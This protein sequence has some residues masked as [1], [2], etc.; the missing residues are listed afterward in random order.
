MT[1]ARRE[2]LLAGLLLL[3]PLLVLLWA[4]VAGDGVPS[5]ADVLFATPFFAE[6][7]PPGFTRPANP[8]AFDVA[9]QFVPWRHFAWTSVRQG[10]LPLW[11]PYSLSGTPF[12]ASMQSAVFYPINLLLTPLPFA[13]TFAWSAL[14]RLWIAGFSA[15]LL[16]R[17][18]RVSPTGALVAGVSFMLCGYLIVWLGHPHTNVAVWL[19]ALVLAGE[20]LLAAPCATS[21]AL[22]A[23]LVGIQFTGGHVETSVD[24]LFCLGL[25]YVLRWWQVGGR[26]LGRLLP[27]ALAIALGTALAAAQLVPFLE[28]LPLSAEY[29]RR[30]PAAV[31]LFDPRCWRELLALPLVL[32]PNLYG[33]PTWPGPYHSYLP[34]GNYNENVLYVGTVPLLLALV[35]LRFRREPPV[36]ALAVLVLVAAGMAFHLPALDWPNALPGLARANPARLRLVTS[37]G[38][39]L[40][41]GFGADAV[42]DGGRPARRWFLGLAAAVVAA[43]V[44]VAAA[45]NLL[46]PLLVPRLAAW[47]RHMVEARYAALPAPT[48]SLDYFYAELDAV[49]AG[50][51]RAF[52]IGNLAMYA[53]AVVALG[54]WL[55]ARGSA[56]G[57]MLVVLAVV[58][59]VGLGRGYTPAV[60]LR[61]FYPTTP[62]VSRLAGDTTLH[63]VTALGETLVPDAHM[64]YGLADVRGLDFPTRWYA[65]YL[66]AAGR[67]PWIAYGT[68]V[69]SADSPLLRVLNLKYVVTTDEHGRVTLAELAHVQPRSFVVH[70]AVVAESEAHALELLRSA[71]DA[72]YSRVVISGP[73]DVPPVVGDGD[74]EATPIAYAPT[75]T[76]W[77]VVTAS[78]G[79]L[80]NTDAYYP[81]WRVY[82]D[83][84]PAPLYRAN[85]AFRAVLVPP[86]QHTVT[87]RYEPRSMR[88]AF[89]VSALA[90]CLI[91]GMLMRP[92]SGRPATSGAPAAPGGSRAAR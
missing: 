11:N 3:V 42:L 72:V 71:P 52:R 60:P 88:V 14:L 45:G 4:S 81:G 30:P 92:R 19:P 13:R 85:V 57:P 48:H 73:A 77:S 2:R 35:A 7:A 9:Y 86:G 47:G 36:R 20:R 15:Y 83:D 18:H 90:A 91:V 49:L 12:V 68:L 56:R 61:D 21:V 87:F 37:F 10:R 69:G 41:A 74:G 46:L 16:A 26:R 32:F 6:R 43:G 80:V 5:G 27:P 29:A 54:G 22:L 89:A 24:V 25:F 44:L 8:L 1:T 79:Y 17:F 59:L 75:E 64:M 55:A 39:A 70:E 34:W 53:P 31:T 67:L 33:N 28:W 62:A 65:A 58:E 66:D 78:G 63:R 82:V 76:A 38:L 50:M 84:R 40:L 23:A 51:P